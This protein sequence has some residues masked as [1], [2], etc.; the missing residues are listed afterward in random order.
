[1]TMIQKDG[2]GPYRQ[3]SPEVQ[4]KEKTK[5]QLWNLQFMFVSL[6]VERQE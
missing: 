3:I 4:T 2:N 5:S 6:E 1:M